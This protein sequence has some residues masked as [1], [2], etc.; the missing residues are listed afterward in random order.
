MPRHTSI[1][2]VMDLI[3]KLDLNPAET[4]QLQFE[5]EE[6]KSRAEEKEADITR[7]NY[8]ADIKKFVRGR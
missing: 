8:M 1:Q 5:I 2:A 6:R 3:T 4:R 7:R